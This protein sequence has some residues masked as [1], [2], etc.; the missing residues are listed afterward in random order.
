MLPLG[1]VCVCVLQKHIVAFLEKQLKG[2]AADEQ[3]AEAEAADT[4]AN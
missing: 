3:P 2:E 4:A 1:C